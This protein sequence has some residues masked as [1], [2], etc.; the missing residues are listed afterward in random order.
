MTAE[1]EILLL[2]KFNTTPKNMK[3]LL[4]LFTLAIFNIVPTQA[5]VTTAE[6]RGDVFYEGDTPLPGANVT[7][8]HTPTGTTYGAVTNFD[9]GFNLL[10]LR[11][12]DPI[13]SL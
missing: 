11:V 10:N 9:G 6:I 3:R 8:V 1:K 12:G 7:A 13:K 4:L 2:Q 5:Q